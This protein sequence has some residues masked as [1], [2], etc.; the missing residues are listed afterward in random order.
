MDP[1]CSALTCGSLAIDIAMEPELFGLTDPD[2]AI[3]VSNAQPSWDNGKLRYS[4][5]LGDSD[6]RVFMSENEEKV[7][8]EVSFAIG[9]ENRQRSAALAHEIDLGDMAVYTSNVG[10]QVLY[11]CEYETALTVSSESFD[12]Q[13]VTAFGEN[14]GIGNLVGGFSMSLSSPTSDGERFIM[15]GQLEVGISWSASL[16]SA[17]SFRIQECTITHGDTSVDVI[18]QG[19]FAGLLEA[20][21]VE[22]ESNLSSAF[23]FNMF[24]ALDEESATQFLSCEV[25]VCKDYCDQAVGTGNCPVDDVMAF[26]RA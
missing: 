25:K 6:Q 19:C 1:D 15:G 8:A 23:A 24:K 10:I 7:V 26:A 5:A 2:S 22:T 16:L 4:K 14:A 17:F 13:T 21:P 11:R 18:K 20:Q 3:W 12:V 9:G